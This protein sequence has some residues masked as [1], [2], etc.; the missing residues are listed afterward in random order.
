MLYWLSS[1]Q[2]LYKTRFLV[3]IMRS[4]QEVILSALMMGHLDRPI[5]D[6]ILQLCLLLN[7]V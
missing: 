2:L 5:G 6:A 3:M 4:R 7:L 1:L